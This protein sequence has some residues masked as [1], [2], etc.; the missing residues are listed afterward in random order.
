MKDCVVYLAGNSEDNI[1]DFYKSLSLLY[2]N[3][4]QTFNCDVVVFHEKKFISRLP[5]LIKTFPNISFKF[6][7]IEF[8]LPNYP[9][10]ILENILEYFPHPTHGNGPIAWGHPGFSLGYR[11]MCNFFSGELYQQVGLND[12]DYY[13][14]LDTD[15]YILKKVTYNVF[16]MMRHHDAIYGFIGAA[17][18]I[19]NSKVV[20]GLWEY[21]KKFSDLS[22]HVKD[23]LKILNIPSGKMYYNNFEIGKISWFK[24]SSYRAFYEYIKESG[25][26][27]TKRWGDAPIRY[28]GINLLLNDCKLI[29]INNI[30]YQHGAI[31]NL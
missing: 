21:C 14:R 12:Y 16:D 15:S 31:Y 3:Y 25:G 23:K 18:Q 5:D 4:L 24:G 11:H 9:A 1:K 2:E 26:I 20:E 7:E 8:K 27:Y 10:S 17:V 29:D 6:F 22:E 19:D 28:L 30:A 13:M